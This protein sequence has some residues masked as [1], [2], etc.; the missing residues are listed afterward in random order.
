[1]ALSRVAPE[2]LAGGRG[3]VEIGLALC[4]RRI[5]RQWQLSRATS[6]D[7]FEGAECE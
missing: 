4:L 3:E 1:M 5:T 6:P 2:V 7:E